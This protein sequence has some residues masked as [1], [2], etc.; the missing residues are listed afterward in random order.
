MRERA[1]DIPLLAESFFRKMRLKNGK[2]I[3]GIREDTMDILMHHTLAGQCQGAQRGAGVCVCNLPHQ[4]DSPEPPAGNHFSGKKRS[5]PVLKRAAF[6]M[7]EIERFELLEALDKAD[8][9]QSEAAR[10]L[11]VSRV[12]VWNRM[13]RYNVHA[14]KK[15]VS[16]K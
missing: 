13:K 11:G 16:D 7:H 4:H 8:G 1:E 3:D 6:N 2:A 14:K 10:I 9:N 12:T 5:R 15:I